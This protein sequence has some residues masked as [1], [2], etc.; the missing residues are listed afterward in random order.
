MP[1]QNIWGVS[2]ALIFLAGCANGPEV[3]SLAKSTAD[4][5]TVYSTATQDFAK[6]SSR[7]AEGDAQR[8]QALQIATDEARGETDRIERGW[9]FGGEKSKID[10][11]NVARETGVDTLYQR[12]NSTTARNKISRRKAVDLKE[13]IKTLRSIQDPPSLSAQFSYLSGFVT[14]VQTELSKLQKAANEEADQE[15]ETD[16]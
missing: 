9:R 6:N 7:L 1:K 10:S 16:S 2:F 8:I 5:A 14:E 11:L 3:R 12:L 4:I 15:V 13:T